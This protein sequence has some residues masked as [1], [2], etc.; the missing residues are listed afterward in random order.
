ME[1]R[2]LSL[3]LSTVLCSH[4]AGPYTGGGGGGGVRGGSDEPPFSAGYLRRYVFTK[5]KV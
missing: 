1:A 5:Q 4:I 3:H 2:L